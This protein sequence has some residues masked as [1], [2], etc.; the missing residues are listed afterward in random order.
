VDFARRSDAGACVWRRSVDA[1][2]QTQGDLAAAR[3]RAAAAEDAEKKKA[4]EAD[5]GG[6]ESVSETVGQVFA[7]YQCGSVTVRTLDRHHLPRRAPVPSHPRFPAPRTPREPRVGRGG[8][9]KSALSL[10]QTDRQLTPPP[11]SRS[12]LPLRFSPSAASNTPA[13]SLRLR[14]WRPSPSLPRRTPCTT[15]SARTS[16]TAVA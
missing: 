15:P 13:T 10:F 2:Q 16:S 7:G 5:L 1:M 8:A 3:A 4:E 6:A 11:R 9:N 12:R 14:P